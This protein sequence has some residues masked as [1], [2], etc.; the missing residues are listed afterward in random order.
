MDDAA[1]GS[2]TALE[3]ARREGFAAA[4]AIGVYTLGVMRWVVGDLD[5]AEALL[6]RASRA[7]GA[8][9]RARGAASVADQHRRH[10]VE[11]PLRRPGLRVVFEE[12]LQPFADISCDAAVGYVLAN[13]AGIAR[14]RG[15]PASARRCSTRRPSD[16][17]RRTTSV[18]GP[19][20]G[21][22]R[23]LELAE[24]DRSGG[25]GMSR[26]RSRAAAAAARPARRRARTRGARP[27]RHDGRRLREGGAASRR[28]ARHLQ[29]RRR[30]LGPREHALAHRR[31]R[32]RPRQAR[33]GR[34]R[35]RGGAGRSRRD[36]AGALD[37]PHAGRARRDCGAAG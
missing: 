16:S 20:S 23:Y 3:L 32:P 19:T 30:S 1:P 24:G 34:G 11:R 21:Q 31:S 4:E 33:R 15:D 28:G 26:A 10:A 36:P 6:R 14:S 13:L 25:A 22:A 18:A 37:R 9:D 35:A 29:A 2:S 17:S 12:T 5:G 7:S 27:D 8:G